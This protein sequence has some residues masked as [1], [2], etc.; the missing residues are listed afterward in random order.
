MS[1]QVLDQQG[2]TMYPSDKWIEKV[3]GDKNLEKTIRLD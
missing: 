1:G 3:N 2:A